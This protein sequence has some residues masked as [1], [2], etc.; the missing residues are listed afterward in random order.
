MLRDIVSWV[1]LYS[2]IYIYIYIYIYTRHV[3]MLLYISTSCPVLAACG[4]AANGHKR[5][6][7]EDTTLPDRV[8]PAVN[9]TKRVLC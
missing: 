3:Y 1:L 5:K 2:Y 6:G 8:H 9:Y 4:H 7:D